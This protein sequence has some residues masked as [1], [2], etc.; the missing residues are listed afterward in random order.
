MDII[1]EYLVWNSSQNSKK[2]R[3]KIAF[4]IGFDSFWVGETRL[5]G[6]CFFF[7]A[8]RPQTP[9]RRRKIRISQDCFSKQ[10]QRPYLSEVQ[11]GLIN[12]LWWNEAIHWNEREWFKN[13]LAFLSADLI[14]LFVTG[15]V[16][17]SIG[18]YIILNKK[19]SFFLTESKE[20]N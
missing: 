13:N 5:I 7:D 4:R 3:R 2:C 17:I 19:T 8:W 16:L 15:S 20:R 6:Y 11:P 18:F 14:G 10:S 12:K 1:K 9:K